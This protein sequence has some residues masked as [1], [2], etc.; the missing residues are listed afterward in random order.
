[1]KKDFLLDYLIC[2]LVKFFGS[3]IRTLPVEFVGALGRFLGRLLYSFDFKHKALAYANLKVAFKDKLS[4]CQLKKLNQEFYE[5]FGQNIL[6]I[7]LIPLMNSDYINKYISIEGLE[8][9]HRALRQGKGAIALTVHAGSWELANI[10]SS[11]LDIP[12][13]MFVRDQRYP[14]LNQLLNQYRMRKGGRLIRRNNPAGNEPNAAKELIEALKDNMVVGMTLDQGGR[15]GELIKFF[16]KEASMAKGAVKAALKYGAAIIPIFSFR[17]RGA[18]LKVVIE[19]AFELEKTADMYKDIHNNLERLVK[20]FEQY[21]YQ[22]PQEYLWSYKIYKYSRERNILVLNDGKTGHLRQSQALTEVIGDYYR[23][24]NIRINVDTVDVLFK[25]KFSRLALTL[26]GLLAGKYHCQGCSWCLASFL[27]TDT[28]RSLIRAKPDIVV[29]CGSTLAAVNF[30]VSRENLAKSMVIMRPSLFSTRKFDLVVMPRHDNPIKR[31]NVAVTEGALNLIG[32]DYLTSCASKL[33]SQVHISKEFII[34]FF[35]GGDTLDCRLGRDTIEKIIIQ[36]KK[37]LEEFDGEILV[38]T[39]RRTKREIEKLIKD[40]F[41][42]Y[43][44]CKLLVIANENNIDF[45]VGGIL[46]LSKFLVIS[47]ESVSMVSEAASAGRYALVFNPGVS[48]RHGRFL[49]YLASKKYIYLFKAE[50][51]YSI[52]GVLQ[53]DRPRIN[54]LE[55]K[56]KLKSMLGEII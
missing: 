34:G 51:F 15:G 13:M 9:L 7:F 36:I 27:K 14:R 12:F 55:D 6:D 46:G 25:N 23:Q 8:H 29:S 50:D 38:T 31:R 3:L 22:R 54:V 33:K 28:H 17:V 45:A 56:A 44:R 21:I 32:Q 39:S 43:G 30:V 20:K 19:P 41:G 52:I 18:F 40:E 42:H 24:K 5:N 35:L 4:P 37:A 11:N 26:S 48:K 47:G 10:I 53:K 1:M 49:N 16:G 2:F